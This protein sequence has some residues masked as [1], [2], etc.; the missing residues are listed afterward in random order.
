MKN[1][2]K[3][4]FWLFFLGF[5]FLLTAQSKIKYSD[6]TPQLKSDL[7]DTTKSIVSDTA[8]VHDATLRSD[9]GDTATVLRAEIPASGSAYADSVT[10]DSRHVPGDS[11]ITK[12]LVRGGFISI[13]VGEDAG[14]DTTSGNAILGSHAAQM[15]TLGCYNTAV[16]YHSINEITTGSYNVIFGKGSGSGIITGIRNTIIGTEV[17]SSAGDI[18]NK[19]YIDNS[20]TN[21]PLI[22]GDFDKD[23]LVI[24]GDLTVTG[25]ASLNALIFNESAEK[26]IEDIA[27][28]ISFINGLG[29]IGIYGRDGLFLNSSIGMVSLEP[30]TTSSDL[31][32]EL[33]G[34][35]ITI[36]ESTNDGNPNFSIGS[37]A[38]ESFMLEPNYNS[39]GQGLDYILFNTLTASETANKGLFKF[40]VDDSEVL[41]I[42]DSGLDLVTGKTISVEV[43]AADTLD[44]N[45]NGVILVNENVIFDSTVTA[46]GTITADGLTLGLDENITLNNATL[47]HNE[48]FIFSDDVTIPADVYDSGWDGVQEAAPKDA[49]YDK[50]ETIDGASADSDFYRIT[51]DTLAAKTGNTIF[52]EDTLSGISSITG[53]TVVESDS[54]NVDSLVIVDWLSI[55]EAAVDSI[56]YHMPILP[57]FGTSLDSSVLIAVDT[58][59]LGYTSH[60]FTIDSCI[61]T[62]Y[63]STPNFTFMIVQGS[64][65]IFSGNQTKSALGTT[66]YST[67]SDATV[68]MGTALYIH[69]PAVTTKP[70][71]V[72]VVLC[73]RWR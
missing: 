11:L 61:V 59:G 1:I 31:R 22:Y 45:G 32:L 66:K 42:T 29:S 63:G 54:I 10:I 8:T 64:T 7:K 37:S 24:N 40:K 72:Q 28:N 58:V 15:M 43:L 17:A 41:N 4:I 30:Y 39:G 13:S 51:I 67:F 47:H 3:Y 36:F 23:S 34:T 50:I 25:N 20:N 55:N 52:V 5:F 70:K 53:L 9:I 19:L 49:I 16:G 60:A 68:P 48:T 56:V 69:F 21:S 57:A 73:G 35:G 18:S 65:D 26:Y 62:T 38:G 14:G 71:S 2:I 46:I 33:T 12:T 27:D 6:F 44:D